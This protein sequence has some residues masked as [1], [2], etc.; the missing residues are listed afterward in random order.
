M[1][2]DV[3]VMNR[4]IFKKVGE[5]LT[6]MLTI[7]ERNLKQSVFKTYISSTD[8]S[9]FFLVLHV[10]FKAIIILLNCLS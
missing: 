8:A 10:Q 7:R 5:V 3:K 6:G 2:L 1:E 4:V 9:D